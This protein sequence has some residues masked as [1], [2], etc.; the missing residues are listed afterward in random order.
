MTDELPEARPV[1]VRRPRTGPQSAAARTAPATGAALPRV[2]REPGRASLIIPV[3]AL[4]VADAA[5]LAAGGTFAPDVISG[6]VYG[7]VVL[8]ALSAGGLHRLRI[9]LR[10]SDQAGRIL[11]ATLVPGL[12]LA[13]VVPAASAVRLALASAGL[14]IAARLITCAILRAAHRRGALGEPTLIIGSG[15]FGAHLA[16]QLR[17]HAGAGPAGGRLPGCRAPA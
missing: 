7:L 11:A 17:E 15:T 8:V 3:L 5:G 1:A 16:D 6:L 12:L 4:P 2:A 9:C 13:A 10:V 14:V